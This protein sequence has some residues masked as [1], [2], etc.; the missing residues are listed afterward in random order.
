MCNRAYSFEYI[1]D[2][3]KPS[4][5][6]GDE[7]FPGMH[8]YLLEKAINLVPSN[9]KAWKC[10]TVHISEAGA[11]FDAYMDTAFKSCPLC[12]TPRYSKGADW[13]TTMDFAFGSKIVVLQLNHDV[14][15][16]GKTLT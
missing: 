2:K 8:P 9:K 4:K 7:A 10:H 14:K 5:K 13:A 12:K 11:G 16:T 6:K 3:P 15:R 1:L